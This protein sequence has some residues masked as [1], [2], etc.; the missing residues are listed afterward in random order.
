MQNAKFGKENIYKPT[1][2]N[3]SLQNET[4]NNRI[5]MIQFALYKGLNV[6]STM[7]PYKDI[8]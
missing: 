4:N 6:R 8:H 7:F 1:I 2:G 3:E 5:K